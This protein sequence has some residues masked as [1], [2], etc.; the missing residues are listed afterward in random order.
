MNTKNLVIAGVIAAVALLAVSQVFAASYYYGW[1]S[2]NQSWMSMMGGT[3]GH[4]NNPWNTLNDQ[5]MMGN[6]MNGQSMNHKQCQQHMGA[7]GGQMMD[8]QYHQQQCEEYMGLNHEMTWQQ[9]QAMY[10]YCHT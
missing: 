8:A 2:R 4:M 5:G 9:C 7:N 3:N 6:M 10:Q 1:G